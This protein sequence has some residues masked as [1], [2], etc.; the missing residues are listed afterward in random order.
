M[1]HKKNESFIPIVTLFDETEEGAI[2]NRYYHEAVLNG[3]RKMLPH[4]LFMIF[5]D[6]EMTLSQKRKY[7]EQLLPSIQKSTMTTFPGNISFFALSRYRASSFKFFFEMISRW[8]TPGRRLD[9]VLIHASDFRLHEDSND[10]YTICEV[11]IRVKSREEYDEIERNF[12][13]IQSEIILGIKSDFYAQRIFDLKGLSADEKTAA[14]QEFIAHRIKRFPAVY[15]YDVFTEMQHILLICPDGF[16]TQRSSRHLGRII[17]VHYLFRH[18]I[19]ESLKTAPNERHILLKIY[20]SVINLEEERKKVLGILIGMN[21]LVD[22]EIFNEKQLLKSIQH[23]IPSSQSVKGSFFTN[24]RGSEYIVTFYIEIE[25]KSEN[26]F[27]SEEIQVL[28][29]QLPNHIRKRIEH[30]HHSIFMPRNEE[31]ILRNI[32]ILADQLKYVRDIPQMLISFDKQTHTELYFTVIIV[33]I[34]KPET[35]P[36][37]KLFETNT[38]DLEYIHNKLHEVGYLRKK[39]PKE[40]TLFQ[41]KL[42]KQKFLRDDQSIDLYK[43]RQHIV[44]ELS[45]LVGDIRDY[46]GGMISKQI[47]LLSHI[48]G[49]LDQGQPYDEQLVEDFFYSFNPDSVRS[50]LNPQLFVDLFNLLSKQIKEPHQQAI[51]VKYGSNP[52]G[53]FALAI[54]SDLQVADR[55]EENNFASSLEF[56][57]ANMKLS[58]ITYFGY[59]C[60]TPDPEKK[61]LFF[62]RIREKLMTP[63][64]FV[65]QTLAHRH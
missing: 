32:L 36:I 49:L 34:L 25:K 23:Y 24:L 50:L 54:C 10:V 20:Q 22:G 15:D 59:L 61:E 2:T 38:T 43:A 47:E 45:R 6:H 33:R 30:R 35:P 29:E 31:E 58:N 52:H 42:P 37:R 62:S 19:L 9:V 13:V 56:A 65:V 41:L 64:S 3:L 5:Q 60:Q 63:T 53:A 4:P 16:K 39:Y 48:C 46:N 14:I 26:F 51:C 21:F 57:H 17:S 1:T 40:S 12:P 8:L 7:F 55:L 44:N 28:R 11:M 27:S 18:L